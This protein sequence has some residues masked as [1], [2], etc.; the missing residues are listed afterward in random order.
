MSLLDRSDFR[1]KLKEANAKYDYRHGG[2]LAY[3]AKRQRKIAGEEWRRKTKQTPGAN[4][5]ENGQESRAGR[6]PP[7]PHRLLFL[8]LHLSLAGARSINTRCRLIR[9]LLS[10]PHRC[11]RTPAP[12]SMRPQRQSRAPVAHSDMP[13][14]GWLGPEEETGTAAGGRGGERA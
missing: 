7:D 1:R 5:Q 6:T 12:S 13:S 3:I 11:S 10:F 4:R 2:I 9:W 8:L 14:L